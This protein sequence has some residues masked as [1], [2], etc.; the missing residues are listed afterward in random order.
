MKSEGEA[1]L[2]CIPKQN[3]KIMLDLKGKPWSTVQ[4]A[5][6]L[7]RWR[8]DGDDISF[9]I[10]GPD[11]LSRECLS[12]ANETWALSNLTLPHP[13]VRIVLIEQLY[14]AWTVLQGHPYHK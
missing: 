10:G 2:D 7:S 14:R 1:I 9:V 4:L 12:Q 5:E 11:G 8:M 3:K 6:S 13:L